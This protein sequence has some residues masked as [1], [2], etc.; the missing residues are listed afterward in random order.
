M[1]ILSTIAFFAL[2]VNPIQA[3]Y[4]SYKDDW[5]APVPIAIPAPS[6]AIYVVVVDWLGNEEF[7][8]RVDKM[9]V[10]RFNLKAGDRV[11]ATQ[12][13]KIRAAQNELEAMKLR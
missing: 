8:M 10:E 4:I 6:K 11:S 3:E 9:I 7:E 5:K 12:A 1:K 13:F 2:M